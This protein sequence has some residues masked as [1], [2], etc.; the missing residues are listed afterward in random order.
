MVQ[1][2]QKNNAKNEQHV[3]WLGRVGYE[4]VTS[5]NSTSPT[6]LWKAIFL[7]P[8]IGSAGFMSMYCSTHTHSCMMQLLLLRALMYKVSVTYVWL[9]SNT[10]AP[11][12][13][14]RT[15]WPNSSDSCASDLDINNSNIMIKNCTKQTRCFYLIL[16]QKV[17][18]CEWTFY[19]WRPY[20]YVV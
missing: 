8:A 2:W 18:S 4:K 14:P 6:R 13:T 12:L 1:Q 7:P 19:I 20:A 15:A 9:T 16:W 11:A 3:T 10:R 17:H 5:L